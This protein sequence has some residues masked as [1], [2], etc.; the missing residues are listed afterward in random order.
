MNS[1]KYSYLHGKYRHVTIARQVDD[2]GKVVFIGC[3]VCHPADSFDKKRGRLM[4]EGRLRAL[5]AHSELIKEKAIELEGKS[6]QEAIVLQFELMEL[7]SKTFDLAWI[8]PLGEMKP[9]E[10]TMTFLV[11]RKK[12]PTC[13]RELAEQWFIERSIDGA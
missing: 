6:K 4:A 9:F 3:S 10:R 2:A 1:V 11:T 13:I 7:T 8:V 5:K 12:V